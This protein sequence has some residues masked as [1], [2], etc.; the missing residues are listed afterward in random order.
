MKTAILFVALAFLA[1]GTTAF[2]A[3]ESADHAGKKL[4]HVVSLKFKPGTTPDEIKQVDEAF[5]ALKT[6]IPGIISMH[7][8]DNISPEQRNHDFTQCFVATFASEKDRDGYL[9]HPDHKAFGALAGPHFAD[10]MVI[11]FW[12]N[13]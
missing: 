2:A 1:S 8:G 4:Y 13:E 9:V 6:K 5:A 3:D 11:D 7:W 12:A 10:V